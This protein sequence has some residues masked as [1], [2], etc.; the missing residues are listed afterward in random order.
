MKLTYIQITTLGA[1]LLVNLA[2]FAYQF[3]FKIKVFLACK[4]PLFDPVSLYM[5]W[6]VHCI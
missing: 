3:A 6:T 5:N 1:T 4:L 2:S